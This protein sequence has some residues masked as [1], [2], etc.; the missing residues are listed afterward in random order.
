M[1][2]IK[3]YLFLALF[4]IVSQACIAEVQLR[5]KD[6]SPDQASEHLERILFIYHTMV[7]HRKGAKV[8]KPQSVCEVGV[9]VNV[10]SVLK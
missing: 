1:D 8:T 10:C 5:L 6:G 7:E 3:D 2:L 9:Q 4:L